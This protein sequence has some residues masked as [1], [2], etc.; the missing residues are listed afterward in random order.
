MQKLAGLII[1]LMLFSAAC[2]SVAKLPERAK[3]QGPLPE[4][5][6]SV[7][8]RLTTMN[9]DAIKNVDGLTDAP[10]YFSRSLKT[11]LEAKQPGRQVRLADEQ[12]AMPDGD[13]AVA[14]ELINID[15]GSAGL[16]FWIG[17]SAGAAES[18][19]NVTILDKA[20]KE[21]ASAKISARTMCPV[22]A[23]VESNADTVRRN[24]NSLASEV[25]EFTLNPGEY[26]KKKGSGS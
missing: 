16:R 4:S 25:A 17:F 1:F 15:G 24:L 11:A 20:G 10:T 9:P 19:V 8:V 2:I 7:V 22:G 23:C 12:G 6:Q 3:I 21:L 26:E 18:L 14:T 13:I 5:V